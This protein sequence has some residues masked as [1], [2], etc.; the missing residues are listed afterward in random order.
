M[1]DDI[2][3]KILAILQENAR[4]SNAEIARRLEAAP[5]GILERIRKLEKRGI[6]T[7]YHAAVDARKLGQYVTAFAFIRTDERPG[8][9]RAANQ[10]VEIPEIQEV[11]HIAGEDCYLVKLR[12]ASNNELGRLLRERIGMIETVRSSRT[13]V[14]LETVKETSVLPVEGMQDGEKPVGRHAASENYGG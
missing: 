5:S 14:V 3:R 13:S 7:G 6:I 4:I 8:D 10:L 11:H 9:I 12:C 2:D 1:I